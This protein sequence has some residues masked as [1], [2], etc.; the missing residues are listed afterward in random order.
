MLIVARRLSGPIS[1]VSSDLA[2]RLYSH[3]SLRETL[4]DPRVEIKVLHGMQS[5][6]ILL[7][8]APPQIQVGRGARGVHSRQLESAADAT[9]SKGMTRAVEERE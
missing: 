8:D 1:S 3:A 2:D 4:K 5:R 9:M 6:I 7:V